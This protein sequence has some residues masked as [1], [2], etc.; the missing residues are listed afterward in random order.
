MWMRWVLFGW[1]GLIY[2]GRSRYG[3]DGPDVDEVDFD[4]D[5][6]VCFGIAWLKNRFGE[7]S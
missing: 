6:D 2:I 7:F 4:V 1:A 5:F 3:W